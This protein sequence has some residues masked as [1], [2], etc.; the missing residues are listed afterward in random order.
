MTVKCL[1]ANA[2]EIEKKRA[3]NFRPGAVELGLSTNRVRIQEHMSTI[4]RSATMS[5]ATAGL[6]RLHEL[7]LRLQEL[8]QQLE[9]GPRQV[10]ARQQ[11]LT[12]KQAE[13]DALKAELKLV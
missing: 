5:A 10:K 4:R 2:F 8:Q 13:V 9:H 7:H 11:I 3:A 12:K 1:K 6:K